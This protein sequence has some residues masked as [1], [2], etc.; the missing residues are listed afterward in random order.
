[1]FNYISDLRS[2]SSGRAQYSME[3]AKYDLVPPALEK[4]LAAGFSLGE[5]D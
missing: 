1:M 5:E 2:I 3:L 4:E